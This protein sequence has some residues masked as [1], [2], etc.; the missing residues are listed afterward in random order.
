MHE[1]KNVI[2]EIKDSNIQPRV[3]VTYLSLSGNRVSSGE[4]TVNSDIVELP[5]DAPPQ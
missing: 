2:L 4:V 5:N 3:I 1:D